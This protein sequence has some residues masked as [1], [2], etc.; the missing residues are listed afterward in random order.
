MQNLSKRLQMVYRSVPEASRVADIGTDHAFLPIAL[1]RSGLAK[2]VIACDIAEG[3]LNIA[4]KNVKK[5]GVEGIELRLSDGLSAVRQ[6]EVDVVTIAGMGGDLISR[7]LAAAPWVKNPHK[8]LVLQAMTSVDSLR[9]YL[10]SE[11]FRII[12]ELAVTDIGRVYSVITAEYD[13]VMRTPT[14]AERLI[15][16]LKND[17]SPD[18]TKY[19]SIQLKRISACAESLR[20]VERKAEKYKAT[21]AARDQLFEI[22]KSR[23]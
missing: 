4:A 10:Y 20:T 16:D 1:I 18:A 11:G 5:S 14:E 15:G 3:P 23:K 13:G 22:L 2:R 21:I 12:S 8:R 9:D 6:D 19:I 17:P 7:I